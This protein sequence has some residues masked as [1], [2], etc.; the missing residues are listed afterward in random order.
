MLQGKFEECVPLFKKA[1]T[2]REETVSPTLAN[3]YNNLG[4]AYQA[5]VL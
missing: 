5:Q 2:I 1:I 3:G 4:L